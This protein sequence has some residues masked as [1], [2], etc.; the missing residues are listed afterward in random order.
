MVMDGLTNEVRQES[1]STKMFADDTG[2]CSDNRESVEVC[3]RE[4]KEGKSVEVKHY[5]CVNER[6]M[7]G[8][9]VE[10]RS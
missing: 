2:I 8:T 7:G 9:W 1:M 4:K 10:S 3:A 6:E 5:T